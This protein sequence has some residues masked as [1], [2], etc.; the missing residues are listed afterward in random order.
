MERPPAEHD[1]TDQPKGGGKP[2]PM[3]EQPEGGVALS[4]PELRRKAD[5]K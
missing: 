2:E 3:V 5:C 1:G 4:L